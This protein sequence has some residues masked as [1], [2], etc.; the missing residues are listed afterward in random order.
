M[1]ANNNE[2]FSK[3]HGFGPEKR[4]V[5]I[6]EDAPKQIREA[7]IIISYDVGKFCPKKLREIICYELRCMPDPNNWSEYPNIYDEV[8]TLILGCEWYKVY[9]IAEKIYIHLK[10][11]HLESP[12][13]PSCFQSEFNEELFKHGIGWKMEEGRIIRRGSEAYDYSVTNAKNLTQQKGFSTANTEIDEAIKAISRRPKPDLT[14]AI[15]HSM[16]ALECVARKTS[17]KPDKTLGAISKHM[18]EK[19]LPKTLSCAVTQLWGYSSECGRHLR[20]G[21]EPTQAEAELVVGIS[22]MIAAYLCRNS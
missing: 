15:Q 22:A 11:E 12:T 13:N 10:T 16:A 18:D 21:E 8:K 4:E 19:I 5:V 17:G 3:R 2:L 20:E 9:D 6:V 14:G 7:L 1:N